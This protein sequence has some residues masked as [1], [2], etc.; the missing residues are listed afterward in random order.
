MVLNK[1]SQ[2]VLC[3]CVSVCYMGAIHTPVMHCYARG[4]VCFRRLVWSGKRVLPVFA[5]YLDRASTSSVL[6]DD[7]RKVLLQRLHLK[8]PHH[9]NKDLRSS[10]SF[11]QR[12][13]P[14]NDD[15]APC[16]ASDPLEHPKL[17]AC[18][19]LLQSFRL[20]NRNL[21]RDPPRNHDLSLRGSKPTK[22]SANYPRRERCKPRRDH[23]D[24]SGP[25]SFCNL[26]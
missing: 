17:H 9:K 19:H 12:R 6:N 22:H 4:R 23:T 26:C 7:D 14:K 18:C 5:G 10:R 2:R 8:E 24:G 13:G 11:N 20:R 21:H 3:F 16:P 1:P 15:F 25:Y